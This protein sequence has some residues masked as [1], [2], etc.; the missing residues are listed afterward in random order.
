[1]AQEG[2]ESSQYLVELTFN[3]GVRIPDINRH[4]RFRDPGGKGIQ[5]LFHSQ[6]QANTIRLKVDR[7]E[8]L[9]SIYVEL[10]EGFM[11]QSGTRQGAAQSKRISLPQDTAVMSVRPHSSWNSDQMEILLET[12]RPVSLREFETVL[13]I[14][15]KTSYAMRSNGNRLYLR[16]DFQH[17]EVYSL[18]I[19]KHQ[20]GSK[21][22][23]VPRA[24]TWRVQMPKPEP[25]LHLRHGNGLLLASGQRSVAIEAFQ[26]KAIDARL[27]RLDPHNIAVWRGYASGSPQG[28]RSLGRS[29]GSKRLKLDGHSEEKQ[30]IRLNVDE[31]F[32][33][34]EGKSPHKNGIWLLELRGIASDP[35][36][37]YGS[38]WRLRK[39]LVLSLSQIGI[40]VRQGQ[41][42]LHAWLH[43]LGD[44]S[45][46]PGQQVR[47]YGKRHA[48]LAEGSSDEGGYVKLSIPAGDESPQV[49]MASAANSEAS[50]DADIAWI[51][52]QRHRLN[53]LD[54][55]K[56]IPWQREGYRALIS[57]GR[58]LIRPGETIQAR[59]ILR[60]IEGKYPG[61]TPALALATP[62]WQSL[63][64]A[65][66]QRRGPRH[67][68]LGCGAPRRGRQRHV[69]G[70]H[71]PAGG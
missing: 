69:A 35:Q 31:L 39:Q 41:G 26:L 60:D 55:Q 13:T 25:S 64:A 61:N 15:P 34:S 52:L 51:D 53:A 33:E 2:K 54:R 30:H 71:H 16:G 24:G 17:G 20:D 68:R 38:S 10:S 50:A 18:R 1:M 70:G 65:H 43:N 40:S 36:Q 67:R 66:R 29:H 8:L 47:V 27:F 62:G 45:A 57:A 42:E 3:Q 32:P 14:T 28:I 63:P 37:H 4:I 21:Q 59:A 44:G 58:I 6:P 5:H 7:G 49:L 12:N 46:M 11:G 56:G 23:L 9:R 19:G 22:S 48:L